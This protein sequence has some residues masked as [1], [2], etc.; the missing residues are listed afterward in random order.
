MSNGSINVPL[1]TT[2]N[3]PTRML[4]TIQM[5]AAPITRESVTGVAALI[6]GTTSSA[7]LPYETRSREMNNRFIISAYC[8][9]SGRSSPSWCRTATTVA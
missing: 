9:G 7:W 4:K 8:T 5:T 3:K 1:K 2:A 6:A